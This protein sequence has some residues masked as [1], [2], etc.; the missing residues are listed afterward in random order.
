MT[1]TTKRQM[2][3]KCPRWV[4][5]TGRGQKG[6]KCPSQKDTLPLLLFGVIVQRATLLR[7]C[8]VLGLVE[9]VKISSGVPF[10]AMIPWS[11]NMT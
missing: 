3:P 11:M 1:D 8:C 7:N 6:V 9:R 5:V 2:R 4:S 10:S